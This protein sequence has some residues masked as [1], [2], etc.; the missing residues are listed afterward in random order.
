M[1]KMEEHLL[2]LIRLTSTDLPTDVEE[3]LRKARALEAEGSRA[4]AILDTILENV[5]LA[6]ARSTPI[7]QD[8]GLLNFFVKHPPG[9]SL[10]PFREAAHRAAAAATERN[11][12]RPNAVHP[13][14]GKNSGNNAGLGLP[15]FYF[16]EG[17][18]PGWTVD[19]LLK[20]GGS[21]NVGF[22]FKLPHG[23][24]Q[25]GR[26][27]EGVRRVVL[28]GV[29]EAQGLGCAPGVLGIGIGGDRASS[30]ALAKRQLLRPLED[31]NPDEE[32]AALEGRLLSEANGLGIGPMGLGGQTTVLGVKAGLAHR[33]P[34]SYFVSV[35]YFCWA[36]RRRR[37]V[38][39]EE[40]ASLA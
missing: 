11:Y 14:T 15:L 30:Y 37:L 23:P 22:Q 17:E 8:T 24:V 35:A 38:L 7:C 1:E 39:D 26:D 36:A 33:H 25:A 2:E 3:A 19:L 34:A 13:V 32:L 18:G 31:A 20:G 4:G 29:F 28:Q 9:A 12:L 10:Q 5:T 16:E 6:R 40:G 21:E 27:L